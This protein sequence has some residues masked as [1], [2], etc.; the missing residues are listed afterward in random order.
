MFTAPSNRRR[1]YSIADIYYKRRGC[2]VSYLLTEQPN[3]AFLVE[4]KVYILKE[5]HIRKD[6]NSRYLA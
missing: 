6:I 3:T 1:Q 5:S 2:S 4:K